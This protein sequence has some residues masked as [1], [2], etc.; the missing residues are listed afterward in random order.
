MLTSLNRLALLI[1]L[2][3]ITLLSASTYAQSTDIDYLPAGQNYDADIPLPSEVLGYPVGSWHVRH[4]QI[5]SYMKLLAEKS[6]RVTIVETG[7]THEQRPLLLLTITSASNHQNVEQIKT[8]HLN[9]IASGTAADSSD[10]LI[11]Y[12]GYS[13]HGNEP[14]GSN[15]SLLV[16]YH[17]AASNSPEVGK[18][19]NENVVLLDPS[20][21]PDGLA[22]FAQWANTHK[23]KNLVTDPMHREHTEHW[24]SGRTNHY[25]FDLNRDWLLLTH[26]ESKA[27]IKQFHA[28]RPHVLTDFHEMGTNS[29]YFFQ[30]GVPSRKNPLTPT[31][32]VTLTGALAQFHAKALDADKQLYFTE[33][34]FDD[35][36]YG[37]GSTY[38]DAH[39]S[40][41][42]LFEQASSRGHAQESINGV[43]TFPRSIQNQVTTSL[44]TFAG[45]M[46]NKAPIL[47]YQKQ[48]Y[49][50]TQKLIDEDKVSGYIVSQGNDESRFERMVEILQS[51]QIKL[52]LVTEDEKLDDIS[53][54]AN[55]AIFI[56]L[57]QSQYRL[58]LSLFSERQRFADNTFYDVSNWNIGLAFNLPYVATKSSISRKLSLADW[59]TAGMVDPVLTPN[60]Y[61]YVFEWHDH[62]AP[63]LLQSLLEKDVQV[64]AA[65]ADFR[66]KTP[67]GEIDFAKGSIVIP[68]ALKQPDDLLSL[69]SSY[70]KKYNINVHTITSGLTSK[71]IDLGSQQF[72][73]VEKPEVLMIGGIGTSSNE[74]GEIWHYLDTRLGIP[75]TLWDLTNLK[76]GS[77][78]RYTHII[79]ASG[80]YNDVDESVVKKIDAW[81]KEGGVLIGQ[82]SAVS[83]FAQNEWIENKTVSIEAL[84]AAFPISDLKFGDQ[85]ALAAKKLVAG[86]VFESKIDLSHPLFFGFERDTLPLFKTS[87]MVLTLTDNPFE[88]IA[89]YTDKPLMAGYAADEMQ[90]LMRNTAAIV[91][92]KKQNGVIIGFVDNVHFRGYWDGTNKLTANAL[93][94]SGLL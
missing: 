31:Q 92:V 30:P 39:G 73:K 21:N 2:S 37:K 78:D 65:G 42:I 48:F 91:A 32:N 68:S 64:R 18:L 46:A 15:A 35:F 9:N 66:A 26:P 58:I 24:P 28:W 88:D 23:G 54:S 79:F 57:A 93:Y 44:S 14:S 34:G 13:V 53:I 67:K 55:K 50:D 80:Q 87:N 63:T 60:E 22:R 74:V 41:G 6:D 62:Q 82:K 94:L 1:A 70:A 11:I 10:P 85:S 45:A 52:Q 43:V 76:I 20:L 5:V 71:G 86:A 40:I 25:W 72:V 7:R 90:E 47:A 51:H 75:A 84:D 3:A 19:L 49:R 8:K 69:L 38:P 4:D 16:A 36:Y 33:E 12:M 27:R 83:W 56:P 81:V 89:K 59:S 61:A 17:L 77:L 29:T